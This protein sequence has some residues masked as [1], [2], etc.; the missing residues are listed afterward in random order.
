MLIYSNYLLSLQYDS[1]PR[2]INY[3]FHL[4]NL[5]IILDPTVPSAALNVTYYSCPPRCVRDRLIY[6]TQWTVANVAHQSV[7]HL[8]GHADL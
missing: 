4:G 3:H 8:G 6:P 1:V 7:T 5:L 2:T